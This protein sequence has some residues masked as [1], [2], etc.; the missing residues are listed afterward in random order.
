MASVLTLGYN[1]VCR[2]CCMVNNI[3]HLIQVEDNDEGAYERYLN[4][5]EFEASKIVEDWLIDFSPCKNCGS[6]NIY[7]INIE[8]ADKLLYDF[9]ELVSWLKP[10]GQQGSLLILDLNNN[11]GEI[12]LD[13]AGKK[14]NDI[15]FLLE[16]WSL[17]DKVI[18]EIP[19]DK[20]IPKKTQGNFQ[21]VFSGIYESGK[22]IVKIEKLSSYG[23]SRE[24]IQGR[25]GQ[26]F[27]N[28]I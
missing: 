17:F 21:M 18:L 12:K 15:Q 22:H 26:Y 13:V 9:D 28:L 5:T 11:Y 8:I 16:C 4:M 2:D 14:D 27:F 19:Y 25:I 6:N 10:Y 3:S 1:P 7:P 23:F 24:S 20:F